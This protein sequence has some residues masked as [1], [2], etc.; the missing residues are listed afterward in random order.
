MHD[1]TFPLRFLLQ[2]ALRVGTV[3]KGKIY[4]SFLVV[5]TDVNVLTKEEILSVGLIDKSLI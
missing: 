4:F 1:S 2:W 3:T 5:A